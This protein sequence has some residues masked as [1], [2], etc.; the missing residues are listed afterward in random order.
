MPYDEEQDEE[1]ELSGY[2]YG[3]QIEEVGAE[4]DELDDILGAMEIVDDAGDDAELGVRRA[5]RAYRARHSY[6]RG[7]LYPPVRR[8][9]IRKVIRNVMPSR[10]HDLP[11]PVTPSLVPA[12][13]SMTI[14]LQPQ[15]PFKPYRLSIPSSISAQLLITDVLVGNASQFV[16]AG[17]IPVECFDTDATMVRLKGDTAVPGVDILLMV[18]NKTAEDRWLAGMIVGDVAQR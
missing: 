14:R 3:A 4:D 12:N 8:G 13:G 2:G 15:L 6:P 10:L 16:A 1:I 11:L 5:R 17:E 7:S 9:P 18:A